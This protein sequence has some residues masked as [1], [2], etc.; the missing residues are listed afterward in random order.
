MNSNTKRKNTK[1]KNSQVETGDGPPIKDVKMTEEDLKIIDIIGTAI[2]EGDPLVAESAT[3]FH[4]S[5]D[6]DENLD[7][8]AKVEYE[9]EMSNE[10]DTEQLSAKRKASESFTS[11]S[12]VVEKQKDTIFIPST[13]KKGII[14]TPSTS[15]K[16]SISTPSTSKKEKT[17]IQRLSTALEANKQ[18]LDLASNRNEG[19]EKY[20]REKLNIYKRSVGAKESEMILYEREVKAKESI[21][22]SLNLLPCQ[23]E[24]PLIDVIFAIYW[25]KYQKHI[26]RT[27]SHDLSDN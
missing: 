5:N 21:A 15:K 12:S 6:C 27:F 18:L 13:S 25:P 10:G 9:I 4:F 14:R 2:V 3:S 22:N 16:D 26:Q 17:R 8:Y 7:E 24:H 19:K 11:Q 1:I 23:P 20:Y